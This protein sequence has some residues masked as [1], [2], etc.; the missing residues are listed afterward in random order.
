MPDMPLADRVNHQLTIEYVDPHSLVRHPENARRGKVD[1]IAESVVKTGQYRPLIVSRATRHVVA[2]NHLWEAGIN[3]GLTEMPVTFLDDL[4]PEAERRI[5]LVDN[6]SADLGTYDEEALVALLE[7]LAELD[8]TGYT[9]DDLE[10]LAFLSRGAAEI[11]DPDTD[12]HYSGSPEEQAERAERVGG[13]ENRAALGLAELIL[14][15]PNSKKEQLIEW[16]QVLRGKWGIEMTNGEI[17][18]AAVGR[19]IEQT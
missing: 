16:L 12:A 6:R 14:V 3:L 10:T 17:I 15:L 9:V 8:G 4:S 18:Y 1:L 19:I 7:S 5:L 2:G 11:A 13:Y